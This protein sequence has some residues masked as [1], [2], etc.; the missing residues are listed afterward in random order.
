[1]LNGSCTK[2]IVGANERLE[3]LGLPPGL[4]EDSVALLMEVLGTDYLE[5]ILVRGLSGRSCG[6]RSVRRSWSSVDVRN[7]GKIRGLRN[8]GDAR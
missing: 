4:I 6:T 3:T 5:Q 2:W 7:R 1:M 8:C